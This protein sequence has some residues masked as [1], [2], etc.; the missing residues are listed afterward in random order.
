MLSSRIRRWTSIVA[1]ASIACCA[2][3]F[4]QAAG[5]EPFLD[6]FSAVKLVAS[7]VPANGDVNPYGI[8][9][10]HRS[11]GELHRGH[12]LVSNFNNSANLQG[13]GTTI[14]QLAPDGSTSVFAHL[15]SAGIASSC[16]GGIGLTTALSILDSGWV[17]VGSLPSPTGQSA[18]AGAGCLLVIDKDGHFAESLVGDGING[19]WDMTAFDDGDQAALFVTN[20]L[21]GNVTKGSPHVVDEGTV[22]RID[23]ALPD[24]PGGI[25]RRI[26]T[27][28]I[29]SG[30]AQT[31]DPNALVIGPTGLALSW[32]GT[33]YLADSLGNRIAAIPDALTRRSSASTGRTVS[34]GGALNDPLGLAAAPNGNLIAANGAD[35]NLVEVS[36]GGKQVA[37]KT[38]ETAFGAGS[39]FGL[40]I[41]PH[42]RGIYFV[43]DGDNTVKKF[44]SP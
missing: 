15:D 23:L 27:T 21:N 38:V 13:T 30:F 26:S 36:P 6:R 41:E 9:V 5:D 29:G 31:A 44:T 32:D 7:T 20:V 8:A 39:L 35:G 17:V 33:L 2:A 37:V 14:V 42:G 25:P 40:A 18:N 22:I 24:M 11:I 3:G 4:A 19:P 28:I 10:V 43:D 16:P 12:V 34:Q 1:L